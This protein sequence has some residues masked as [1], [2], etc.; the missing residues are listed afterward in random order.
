MKSIVSADSGQL[1]ILL[2]AF[3]ECDFVGG[4]LLIG[5]QD[6]APLD[7]QVH[8]SAWIPEDGHGRRI[9]NVLQAHSVDTQHPIIG[10]VGDTR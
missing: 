6:D 4:R 8:R 10:P 2:F 7:H 9:I 1:T 3:R 5:G